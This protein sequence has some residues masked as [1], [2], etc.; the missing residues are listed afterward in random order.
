MVRT[1]MLILSPDVKK[2]TNER[3]RDDFTG[4]PQ[5]GDSKVYKISC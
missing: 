1:L 3:V 2:Y 4:F 5:L